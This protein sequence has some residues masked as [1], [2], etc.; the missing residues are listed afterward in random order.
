MRHGK[1]MNVNTPKAKDFKGTVK[2]L[3]SYMKEYKIGLIIVVI[4][5]ILST[6]F[7]IIGP[8]ILGNA[9]T[10]LF[11]GLVSK[12]NGGAGINFDKIAEILIFLLCLYIVSAIFSYI[13][14]FVMSYITQKTT[15]KMRKDINEKIDRLPMSYFDKKSHGEVLSIIT[16]DVDTVS[17]SLNQSATQIVTSIVTII[18]IFVMMLSINI[19]L[20]II[21]FLILPLSMLLIML[22]VKKAKNILDV[23]K[24][25]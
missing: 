21:S 17:Q 24:I 20:T 15:Y 16:N 9:T 25:I 1:N 12:V 18:G 13:Q 10:E 6:I 2:K 8:K 3:F 7:S 5:A 19:P 23:N 11:N 14:G 4:V 22:V